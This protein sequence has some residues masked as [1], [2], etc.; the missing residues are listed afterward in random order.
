MTDHYIEVVPLNG[1]AKVPN[2]HVKRARK[3]P[4]NSSK[5]TFHNLQDLQRQRINRGDGP[6]ASSLANLQSALSAF[7]AEQRL[8]PE[9]PV[10]SIFRASYYNHL[11]AHVASLQKENRSKDY[12]TNRRA[13]LA[14]W[15][16]CVI[17]YDR[18]CAID[19]K[20]AHPFQQALQEIVAKVPSQRALARDS[21]IPLATLKR[22]LNGTI[23]HI[24]SIHHAVNLERLLCLEPGQLRDLLPDRVLQASSPK[25]LPETK[26]AYRVRQSEASKVTYAVKEPTERLR[27]EWTELLQYKVGEL[28][29]G[30][31]SSDDADEGED[32]DEKPG[33]RRSTNGRWS[34][35]GAAVAVPKASNWFAF[36]RGKYVATACIKWSQVAQFTGWLMLSKSE[37]G[38]EMAADEAQKLS[39]LARRN[40][41]RAHVEWRIERTGGK[42]HAGIIGFLQ[43][44]SSLCNPRTGYLTQSKSRVA[45][46]D[47]SDTEKQ[48]RNRCEATFDSIRKLRAELS[49]DAEISRDPFEPIQHV[50]SLQNP[51][52]AIADMT[53]R[54]NIAK[55][56]TGGTREAVWAR[57]KLLVKLLASNPLRDK[58]MR[59]LSYRPDNKGH[60]RKDAHGGWFIFVPRRE[61]KNFRGAARDRDYSMQVRPEVWSDIDEYLK[62]YRP[63]LLKIATDRFFISESSGGPF[64]QQGLAR[65]FEK[66]T[67][68]HLQGCPGVGPHAM[69]HIV[70]TSIL[71][72][73]PNDWNA[74]AW[75]LHDHE[76]TVKA[77]YAHLAQHDAAQWLE[78]SF[79][80]PFGRM[81]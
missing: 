26:I 32:G 64:A 49:Q 42:V 75:A 80:G 79:G 81:R 52:D 27:R 19:L 72:A 58:N 17:D 41:V 57:D 53:M 56:C 77:H 55:P 74:A 50:L 67:R 62:H 7:L 10:G 40:L 47:C 31:W 36:Y 2:R 12:I 45:D 38:Q 20:Q 60:L 71:K 73:S 29:T 34:S 70:A 11:R 76:E 14:H 13:L 22:W 28:E 8:T 23:P 30:E 48:W 65:R 16:K 37:G 24:G 21:G 39:N 51:L 4:L 5:L 61:L 1:L 66:M 54:I 63:M 78:K 3:R 59:M 44:V 25:E 46:A 69:R 6:S 18:Y 68:E 15:R 33:L 43:F 35:T 9:M